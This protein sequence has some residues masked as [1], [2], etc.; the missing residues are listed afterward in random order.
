MEFLRI[1]KD[2]GMEDNDNMG[3]IFKKNQVIITA[4]AIMIAVAGYL[5]FAEEETMVADGTTVETGT[6]QITVGQ[7]E[8]EDFSDIS[9]EDLALQENANALQASMLQGEDYVQSAE[10]N[11]S[12]TAESG[13]ENPGEAVLVST[14]ISGNYA[15]NAKLAREQVRARNKELLMNII[16]NESVTEEQK[17]E[18]IDTLITMTAISEKENAAELLLAAKGFEGAVVNIVEESVDVVINAESVTDWQI[19]Q[20]EDIVMRKTGAEAE[21]IV[22]MA[23]IQEE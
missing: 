6:Y 18:A 9:E 11:E 5:Q 22:I 3:T 15:S 17:Q 10:G 7:M 20:I 12:E 13:E 8:T 23:A 21:N 14:I 16:G 19:A 4:L 2:F 1:K